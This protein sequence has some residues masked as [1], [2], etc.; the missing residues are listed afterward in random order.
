MF[1]ASEDESAFDHS[2]DKD[3]SECWHL[4]VPGSLADLL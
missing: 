3:N 4:V 2:S 1:G